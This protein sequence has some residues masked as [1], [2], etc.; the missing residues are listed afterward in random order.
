M[1]AV[2]KNAS[3]ETR[4]T[5]GAIAARAATLPAPPNP[6][7]KR[8][9]HPPVLL[10]EGKEGN[11]DFDPNW[12]HRSA[13]MGNAVVPT[14]VRTV[15]C[16]LVQAQVNWGS[17]AT[18]LQFA[19]VGPDEIGYPFNDSGLIYEGRFYP[20][21]RARAPDRSGEPVAVLKFKG[22]DIA[23][24]KFPTPRRGMCNATVLTERGLKD[25]PTV[26]VHCDEAKQWLRENSDLD[27]ETIEG[28]MLHK[29]CIPNVR[30]VEY[31]MGYPGGGDWTRVQ[32]EWRPSK[33]NPAS[34]RQSAASR[35]TAQPLDLDEDHED[36]DEPQDLPHDRQV[37]EVVEADAEPNG[38][39]D[40]PEGE[41]GDAG[42]SGSDPV[43]LVAASQPSSRRSRGRGGASDAGHKCNVNSMHVF[44][45]REGKGRSVIEVSRMW[46]ALSDEERDEYKAEAARLR[47]EAR[48]RAAA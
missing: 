19:S 25:L 6:W 31:I 12:G 8:C 15:F 27:E 3:A 44:M 23:L 32:G 35:S 20:L 45:A 13:C 4:A 9:P 29:Y 38:E 36:E 34:S 30:Y 17:L 47:A 22:K 16:E 5:L 41:E 1:L 46:K 33:C 18:C 2:K 39:E 10:R 37:R 24:Q 11:P 21:P 48:D 43:S 40:D 7:E 28:G 14:V 26:L 42:G